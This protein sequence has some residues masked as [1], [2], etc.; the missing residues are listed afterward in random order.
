MDKIKPYVYFMLP[1]ITDTYFT[2]EDQLETVKLSNILN[3]LDYF[4]YNGS[5]YLNLINIAIE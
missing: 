2:L 5:A 4:T 1:R 3:I